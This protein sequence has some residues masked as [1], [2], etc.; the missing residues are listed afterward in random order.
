[1]DNTCPEC[2]AGK[3][4]FYGSWSWRCGSYNDLVPGRPTPEWI[5]VQSENCRCRVELAKLQA[6]AK[7]VVRWYYEDCISSTWPSE[8]TQMFSQLRD[9][10]P[11]LDQPEGGQEV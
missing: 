5:H 8:T 3:T 4:Q 10:L 9:A 6:A 1:M 7:E 11:S 2:G